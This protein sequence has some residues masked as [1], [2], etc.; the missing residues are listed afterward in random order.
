GALCRHVEDC[1]MVLDA[2]RGA[3]PKDATSV[4]AGFMYPRGAVVEDLRFGWLARDFAVDHAGAAL[5]LRL[6]QALRE[7]GIEL[8]ERALPDLPIAAMS[9]IVSA[10]AAAAFDAFTRNNI[11]DQL[12]R[13]SRDAWPNVF[14]AARFIPAVEY[15]QANRLRHEL[16]DGVEALLADIDVLLAPCLAGEQLLATNLTGH[17]SLALP[18]GVDERGMPVAICLI[19]KPF[20]EGTLLAAAGAVQQALN[21]GAL[22]PPGY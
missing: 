1:G 9:F 5:D 21:I 12:V 18:Y 6:L 4:D 20:Q 10:E 22:R 17:P 11:D 13:Q 7:R 2:I 16:V 14:R 8:H 3:D 15:L 19:G